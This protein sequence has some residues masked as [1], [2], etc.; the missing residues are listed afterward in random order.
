MAFNAGTRLKAVA[1]RSGVT[2]ST[3]PKPAL[4]ISEL[5]APNRP[6][7][8]GDVQPRVYRNTKAMEHGHQVPMRWKCVR[9]LD[10]PLE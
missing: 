3:S 8:V 4:A 5:V 10:S 7:K 9:R 6:F 1:Q 2:G